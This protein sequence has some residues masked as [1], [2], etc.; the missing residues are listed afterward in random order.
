M[1]ACERPAT[2]P[3]SAPFTCPPG[4][5][6]TACVRALSGSYSGTLEDGGTW[7]VTVSGDGLVTGTATDA[8]GMPSTISGIVD[9]NGRLLMASGV[10]YFDGQIRVDG[11]VWGVWTD[12]EWLR[13]FE[14]WRAEGPISAPGGVPGGVGGTPSADQ[15]GA[16]YLECNPP[17]AQPDAAILRQCD[18]APDTLSCV[19]RGLSFCTAFGLS[20]FEHQVGCA[21]SEPLGEVLC[22]QPTWYRITSP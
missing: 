11:S 13:G 9:A 16:C 12:K 10:G 1:A 17:P 18:T 15:S 22:E 4:S 7:Q 2:S 20:A 14:G 6:E 21:C 5:A 3:R 19:E 8:S